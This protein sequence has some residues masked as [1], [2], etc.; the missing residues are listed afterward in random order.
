[1]IRSASVL[2]PWSMWAMIEKLR[3][4]FTVVRSADQSGQAASAQDR[5]A[6]R[7][8]G[9]RGRAEAK[10]KARRNGDAPSNKTY[11]NCLLGFH[12]S[13]K[14]RAESRANPC[15]QAV[16]GRQQAKSSTAYPQTDAGSRSDRHGPSMS[17]AERRKT[18][19]AERDSIGVRQQST[20][21]IDFDSEHSR[22]HGFNRVNQCERL[23]RLNL[24]K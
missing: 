5:I 16:A 18:T 3:M 22:K 6:K 23:L 14:D 12:C 13:Q 2:L 21:R 15:F 19:R 8:E 7:C 20:A 24:A 4:W 1:M 11:G 17:R 9:P 10:K